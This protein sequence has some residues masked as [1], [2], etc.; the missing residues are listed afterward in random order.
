MVSTRSK[1]QGNVGS[2]PSS[3]GR[4]N[5]GN[6]K[7][8]QDGK[9]SVS[10]S[11]RTTRRNPKQDE[12]GDFSHLLRPSIKHSA[13]VSLRGDHLQDNTSESN[14]DYEKDSNFSGDDQDEEASSTTKDEG[15]DDEPGWTFESSFRGKKDQNIV[16]KESL[17]TKQK[18]NQSLKGE[19]EMA[20]QNLIMNYSFSSPKNLPSHSFSTKT[21]YRLRSNTHTETRAKENDVRNSQLNQFSEDEQESKPKGQKPHTLSTTP[22]TSSSKSEPTKTSS[23][24]QYILYLLGFLLLSITS[25]VLVPNLIPKTSVNNRIDILKNF[26]Q[27][28]TELESMYPSQSASLWSRSQRML[29]L[30]LNNT[31]PTEPAILLLAAARDSKQTLQ[32]LSN[33]LAKA[34]AASLNRTYT[35]IHGDQTFHGSDHAKLLIDNALDSG[36]QGNSRAAVL[37]R[38]EMLPAG[39]LLILYKYCDHENAAFKNVALV[40]TVLLDDESLAPDLDFRV[41]EEKVGDFLKE[42]FTGSDRSSSHREMDVDKLSG[43]WSRISHVVLPVVS[44]K[45]NIGDCEEPKNEA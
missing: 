7:P 6:Q 41:L 12:G 1:T 27:R 44:E 31:K 32:C 33:Q 34:Y 5:S 37:H 39:S 11:G 10:T 16:K 3:P 28:L 40:I 21:E 38:M 13:N 42:K 8:V 45:N 9:T 18:S 30:H 29:Q 36:F 2:N 22:K 4:T 23:C 17:N 24:I 25:Y 43:V 26:Q 20:R 14:S 15:T 35:V 19:K